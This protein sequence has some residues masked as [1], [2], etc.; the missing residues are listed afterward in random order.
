MK[1]FFKY[2]F[3]TITGVVI[4][5][6]LILIILGFIIAGIVGAASSEKEF[7]T[8]ENS[9]LQIAFDSP[10]TERTANNPFKNFN[11]GGLDKN[12]A[13]LNDI[14]QNIEKAESDENIKGA[15]IDLTSVP[16][17]VATME[18]IRNA[19]LHFKK[20]GKFI[21]AYSENYTQG[22]YYL[23]S[24]ADK[25]YLNPEGGL[26]WKGLSAQMMFFKGTLEKLEVEAQ[27][28]KHGK[29][30]S[31][32]EPFY[33]DKLS[34]ANREQIE[35]YIG[36][37]WNHLVDGISKERKISVEE[38]NN[39][40]NNLEIRSAKNALEKKMVDGLLYKDELLAELRKKLGIK[41]NKKINYVNIADYTDKKKATNKSKNKIAIVY[42]VG[43]I[44][45]GEGDDE[46]IGSERISKA[47]R[48][49]RMDSSIKAVVLRVNSPGGSALASD[50]IWREVLLT[51]KV[52]PVVVSMG[53]VAASGGYYI[54]CAADVIVAEPNT[55][56]GSIGVI[57]MIPNMK[58]FFNN[59]LGITFDTVNTNR[60]SDFGGVSRAFTPQE[61][62][63]IEQQIETIYDGFITKVAEG[64]KM[65]KANVDSLGQGR[66]WIGTDA[67]E[68]GLVDE[69]GGIKEAIAIAAKKANLTDY[70]TT[71]LP[72]MKDPLESLLSGLE[73]EA[74]TRIM[75]NKLGAEYDLYTH[76]KNMMN[77]KGIQARMPFELLVY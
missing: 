22:A 27:I 14:L 50:V 58:K 42:A 46:T 61:R 19:L 7:T 29:Y 35:R 13:G 76:Y 53:D 57:G 2:V 40:A 47:L 18:E 74:S 60:M 55:I 16:A 43:G 52:K 6:F 66:V 67:K 9:V 33:A 30:K 8:K 26:D 23:A 15:L 31:A 77:M 63:I 45:G 32:A 41:E 62:I 12:V 69:L 51:K 70:K 25:I 17:G 65:T 38:L 34:P 20:S 71:D 56:T 64:R 44:E 54:S 28:F 10:I 39:I 72:K 36:A 24:T 37:V 73:E 75:K 5:F 68:K 49:A 4:S 48:E 11:F 1:Q 21:L 3:A 59:K